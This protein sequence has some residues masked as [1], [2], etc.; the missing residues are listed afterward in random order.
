MERYGL[1]EKNPEGSQN[2]NA[3]NNDNDAEVEN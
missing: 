3:T 1:L 2:P